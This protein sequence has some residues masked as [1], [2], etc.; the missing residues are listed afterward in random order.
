MA[1]NDDLDRVI[2]GG[3]VAIL[4]ASSGEQLVQAAEALYEGGINV[5]EVP[6]NVPNALEIISAI[7]QK[8]GD[9]ILLGAGSVLDPESARTAMRA[10]AEF[11]VAPVVNL[12]VIRMCTRYGKLVMPGAFT[13]T[14][15][16]TAWEAGA[17]IVKLFPAEIG[18][19]KHLK[20]LRAPLPQVR[21]LPTG[22]VRLDSIGDF[23]R[24]GACAVGLGNGLIEKSALEQGNMQRIRDLASQYVQAVRTARQEP[25][26]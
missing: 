25:S 19:L 16:L 22:G 23:L 21:L 11:I 2:D 12:D 18:G 4:R 24:A 6:L 10:G 17:D 14:E 15:V 3:I 20:A 9:K 5:L 1:K 13:P 26:A 8:L 7:D